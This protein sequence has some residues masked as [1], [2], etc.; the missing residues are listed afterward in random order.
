MELPC[1]FLLHKSQVTI[2][3]V[4]FFFSSF[5]FDFFFFV[6]FDKFLI[7][8]DQQVKL[9]VTSEWYHY[10]LFFLLQYFRQIKCYIGLINKI[11]LTISKLQILWQKPNT[12]KFKK[13]CVL[14]KKY[15]DLRKL[16]GVGPVDNRPSTN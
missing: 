2:L 3:N 6:R 11:M 9:L 10:C 12:M 5:L 8:F 1:L 14:N 13:K 4:F 15:K 7:G 16:D